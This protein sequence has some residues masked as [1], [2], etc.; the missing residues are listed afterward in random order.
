MRLLAL[1]LIST[2][3][4]LPAAAQDY[5][6]ETSAAAELREMCSTDRARLWGVDLCGP[7]LVADPSTRRVWASQSDPE[8]RLQIGNDGWTGQLPAG[9][10]IANTSVEWAGLRWVMVRAPLPEVHVERRV[11][12]GHEAWHRIQTLLG[13]PQS[14]S[15]CAHLETEQ[16]RYL[17]RLEMRALSAAMRSSGRARERAAREALFFRTSRLRAFVDAAAHEAALDRNEGLAS[18]TGVRLGAAA[19]AHSYAARMLDQYDRHQA[20]AHAYAYATGPAYGLLLD[21]VRPDWRGEL[22]QGAAPADILAAELQPDPPSAVRLRRTAERYGGAAILAEETA[23]QE[24]RRAEIALLRTRF[25]TGPRLE[26]PLG[27]MQIEFD[28]TKVTPIEGMGSVYE[29]LTLRDAW[30]ELRAIEGALISTD[31]A[32]LVV[33]APSQ[34][35]LSGPGWTL[36]LAPGY[37]LVGPGADGAFRPQAIP[38]TE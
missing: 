33:H 36:A 34:N 3:I 18:Y 38:E 30:G 11:L 23:H 21:E 31:L 6:R 15:D 9:V 1:V 25:T 20:Y 16:G 8:G 35:G 19:D 4:A 13:L 2:L 28:P 26:L 5:A 7:L 14:H 10:T 17:L 32:R 37:R 27:Q 22:R 29:V 12:L 24:A